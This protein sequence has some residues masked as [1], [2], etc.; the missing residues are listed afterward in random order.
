M[1]TT[2]NSECVCVPQCL[3][4][5]VTLG[6]ALNFGNIAVA[7]VVVAVAA[8]QSEYERKIFINVNAE[9]NTKFIATAAPH[10]YQPNNNK[11][12]ATSLCFI[13]LRLTLHN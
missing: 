2:I 8:L 4:H 1:S 5:A 11:H 10:N 3:P 9:L 13:A 6:V 7:I 12:I